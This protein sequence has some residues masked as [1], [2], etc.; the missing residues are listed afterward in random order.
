ME[1]MKQLIV[2]NSL[3]LKSLSAFVA[4]EMRFYR[5]AADLVSELAPKLD[6]MTITKE[7]LSRDGR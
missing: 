1:L 7:A 3:P 4:A 2:N 6:E 5:D